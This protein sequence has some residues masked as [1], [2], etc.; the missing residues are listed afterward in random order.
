M[1]GSLHR[2]R[3][4]RGLYFAAG[5]AALVAGL[6]GIVL[7]V[8]PTTP[9]VLLAAACFA[10]SSDRFYNALLNHRLT[11]PLIADWQTHGAMQRKTKHWAAL[12]MVLSFG[13]SILIMDS[14][15]HRIMLLAMATVLGVFIWRV[16]VRPESP[17]DP[18]AAPA[19][20][21]T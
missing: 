10:K 17:A 13:T 1:E 20:P 18:T 16:P 14:F 9:F 5:V 4:L 12:M 19:S 6:M 7:P 21:E 8:L 3:W 2:S 11:G 15:W